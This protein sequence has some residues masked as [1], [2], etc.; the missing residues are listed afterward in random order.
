MR[1]CGKN[2]K[3]FEIATACD[4]VL[5]DISGN[6]GFFVIGIDELNVLHNLAKDNQ[7]PVH[8]IIHAIG[9][10]ITNSKK[11]LLYV[12]I[13]AKTIQGPLEKFI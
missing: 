5:K 7:R 4:V 12:P 10:L 13:L 2:W 1:M 8:D 3:T 9:G 6:I 11:N